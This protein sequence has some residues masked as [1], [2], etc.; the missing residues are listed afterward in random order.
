VPITNTD[1]GR[2]PLSLAK[3]TAPQPNRAWPRRRLFERLDAAR[4]DGNIIWVAAPAGSGKTTLIASYLQARR[5]PA[6][7][8]R[9]DAA[10]AD[11]ASFFHYLAQTGVPGRRR[12]VDA[13]PAFTAEYLA[14]LTVFARNWF[15]RFFAL[16]RGVPL[17]VL[18][19]YHQ[20]PAD[21]PVHVALREGLAEVPPGVSVIVTSRGEPPPLL[22][23]LRTLENF[24]LLDREALRLSVDEC[25]AVARQRLAGGAP[26]EAVLRSLHERTQGWVAGLVLMLERGPASALGEAAPLAD[27][28][29]FDYFAGELLAQAEPRLQCFLVRTAL[30]PR[31]TVAS[32]AA[33]TG[34][35]NAAGLLAELDR[36]NFFIARHA[37]SGY[38][39]AWEY[40]PLFREFLL[41][42]GRRQ[43]D[44]DELA[45]ARS[46]A[47]GLLAA[48]GDAQGSV[49]LLRE[50]GDWPRLVS[51]VLQQAP[52]LLRSGRFQTLAEWILGIPQQQ[53]AGAPWLDYFLG[54]SR[55]PY[56][57]AQA[58][59]LL[60][61]AYAGFRAGGHAV[62]QYLSWAGIVDT[63]IYAWSDFVSSD[64]WID[65][66]DALRAR[67]P[68]F[69]SREVEVRA[70]AAI[71]AILMYRRPQ[72]AQLPD[73]TRRLDALVA[74]DDVDPALRMTAA[75]HLLLYYEWWTGNLA[76]ANELVRRIEPF[77]SAR[78]VGPFVRLAW[79]GI[80][81]ISHWMNADNAAALAAVTRGLALAKETG[82][83]VWDFML[84]AQG[85]VAAA[86][87]GDTE[88]ARD[89]LARLR[90]REPGQRRLDAV[91]YHFFSFQEAMRRDDR[92]AMLTHG[93][94]GLASALEAGVAWGEVYTRPAL[95][96]AL[97]LAGDE[98]GARRELERATQVASAIGCSNAFYYMHELEAQF[99]R[100]RG[101][102]PA[103]LASIVRMFQVMREQGFTN[104][105]WWRDDA[106]ARWCRIALEHSI[107]TDFVRAL[108]RRRGL[109]PDGPAA[110]LEQW[111]WPVRV[112]TLGE[113]AIELGGE[114][115]RFA[116]KVQKRPLALLKALVAFGC[117]GVPE[118]QLA[119]ALWPDA[120][121][122][123]A[124]NAFVT[125]LQR[126]RKLLGQRDAVV[127]QEGRLSLNP[128]LCWVDTLA[129]QSVDPDDGDPAVADD[130]ERALLLYRGAFLAQEDAPW[131][132]APRERLRARF[133]RLGGADVRHHVDGAD[134]DGA[135]ACLERLLQADAT[136]EPFYQQLM[137]AHHRLGRSAEV[138]ATYRRCRD[139]L[140]ATLHLPPS[141]STEALLRE[142]A[143]SGRTA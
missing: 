134:W 101:D 114:P 143:A 98:G 60:S 109:R 127:L 6:A 57:P 26:G 103:Q 54:L 25:I 62:G 19:D 96:Q 42:R 58:R 10:D 92:A 50:A 84:V 72:H 69:P 138:L 34:E 61:S 86:T 133:V 48:E 124:H 121:G 129:F 27:P 40:H 30:L 53:R 123:D 99:A 70:V 91:Q 16:M 81:A 139:V 132:I 63:F 107:E 59:E 102:R 76:R 8:Y 131:A 47:A 15:R 106:M 18:D 43:L 120:E 97:F 75:T 95:A 94:A 2:Q 31:F 65:E 142:L 14:G 85:A 68:D 17:L 36:R 79:E 113:F 35:E 89:F 11:A 137:R 49:A 105:A 141:A 28:L 39:D 74:Q 136:V 119:E 12:G 24:T 108:I 93:H 140:G 5:L 125:T 128:Q 122:D 111:P 118:G 1:G 66:F 46:E 82:A 104:S 4:R 55:L 115:L 135:V 45:Q 64:P 32:A 29:V 78:T 22:T 44:P 9:I 77:A 20:L 23:R 3:L 117:V 37:R 80:L 13:L 21:S 33:L 87:S 71:F 100:A 7:W 41:E 56:D 38:G 130:R 110:R 83:H 88:Q 67:H 90:A 126:L 116:G 52:A 112:R 73:W 51:Q